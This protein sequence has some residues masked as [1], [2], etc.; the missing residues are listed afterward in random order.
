MKQDRERYHV[1]ADSL[2]LHNCTERFSVRRVE[3]MIWSHDDI[4]GDTY[5]YRESWIDDMT[6]AM[7]CDSRI[8]IIMTL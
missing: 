4:Y 5:L 6:V 8:S 7:E 2:L 3:I 1:S